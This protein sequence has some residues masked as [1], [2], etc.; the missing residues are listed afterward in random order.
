[1][2]S[3]ENV[4]PAEA[5]LFKKKLARLSQ[6]RG[7]GTEL[8]SVYI[9]EDADRGS[10]MGQLTEEVSQSSNIKSPQTRKNVQGALRKILAFLK[11]I[12]FKIPRRGIVVFAGNVSEQE[13][14]PDLRLFTV[15]PVKD[16]KT[17]LYWC[18]S[19][20]HLAPLREM[21]QPTEIYGILAIDK[22]EATI[23][24]IIGKKYEIISHFNSGY[25]GKFKA[26]GWS[27]KRF[28]HLREEA[29]NEFYKRISEKVNSTFM[30]YGDKL[31]GII[32]GGPGMTKNYFLNRELIDH[33][34]SEKIIGT[35]DTSYTDESGIREIV[36]RSDKLLKETD[37]MKERETIA[38]FM[39]GIAKDGLAIYG[40]N[41]INE[42]LALGKVSVMLVSEGIDWGVLKIKCNNCGHEIT[43]IDKERKAEISKCPKCNY[44]MELLEEI[45][46]IDYML[47]K[48]AKTGT[49]L[50]VIS[51][52]TPEGEQFY[53]SFGGLGAMLRYK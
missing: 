6:F 40:E 37:L 39:E 48:V 20:F 32:V 24:N 29:E 18:D 47:E 15:H 26:G 25:H 34:L 49:E 5:A 38:K 3:Y 8:I 23:A 31:K 28:E 30:P 1:M 9:P 44:E 27:A 35:I 22:N 45:D 33:R 16:L 14:R 21:M 51:T 36:Q 42:A 52:E 53:K 13:G 4:D 11:N 10:V 17:K 46:Y 19:E 12:N 2:K 7:R 41:E 43:I 50:K